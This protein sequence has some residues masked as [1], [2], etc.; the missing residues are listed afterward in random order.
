MGEEL[1]KD[2]MRILLELQKNA[3]ISYKKLSKITGIPPST[4]HDRVKRFTETG[5]IKG[6]LTLLNEEA[7]GYTHTAIIGVETGAQLYNQVARSLT[8]IKEVVEVYGTTAQ[9]D[10]MIKIRTNSRSH[11]SETL[12]N[13]RNIKGINDINVA[14][15]IEIFKEEHTLPFSF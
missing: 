10:L 11:L 1:D 2:D 3:K 4:I 13:I 6:Y 15:I 8:Q 7:L 5:V 9:Y 12:N 14:S